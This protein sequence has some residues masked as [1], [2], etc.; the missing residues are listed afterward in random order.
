VTIVG[1][2]L[3]ATTR[4]W[5]FSDFTGQEL[6]KELDGVSITINGELG[7]VSY[8]SPTQINFLTPSYLA[9]GPVELMVTNNG[10]N[11]VPVPATL[12]NEA[13]SFFSLFQGG[14]A[15]D[16]GLYPASGVAKILTAA[17][18]AYGSVAASVLPG[19][20]VA[21][22]GN[23]FGPT[24]SAAPNGQL[25]ISPMALVQPVQVTI[26]EQ[27]APV[28]FV[29]LVGPGLY[30][31]NVVIPAVDPKYRFFGVP[32]VMSIVDATVQA[33]GFIEFDW[34]AIP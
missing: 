1:G 9:P 10:L 29:G 22:F 13:P 17:L 33:S 6:P 25:L 18:H 24:K 32:V 16:E 21:L 15:D 23:G 11:S 4:S 30:Q 28:T 2:S 7:Y 12:S 8:I 3:S 14:P 20:T 5:R 26:G 34:L 19:E 31:V 27:A